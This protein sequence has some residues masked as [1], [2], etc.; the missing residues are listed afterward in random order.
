MKSGDGINAPNSG[1]SFHDQRV[2][3]VFDRHVALSVPEY[4]HV[5]RLIG[6]LSKFFLHDD[7]EVIDYGCATGRTIEEIARE[8]VGRRVG[9]IGVD[10]S[11]P[12]CDKARER[13]SSIGSTYEVVNASVVRVEPTPRTSLMV[14]VYVL[15]FMTIADR[16]DAL[17]MMAQARKGT[18]LILVEKTTPDEP[19]FAVPFSDI[20]HDE[21]L[22]SYSPEEVIG[23]ARSLRGVL[24]PMTANDTETMLRET[25]WKPQRFWQHLSFVGWVCT[26]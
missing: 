26:R 11:V 2:A 9:Y 12:M 23:K 21:K 20:H 6:K 18:G 10:E 22:A 4:D 8:N 3:D 5:Q 25:G 13:L 15:Q 7:A 14:A 16:A 17:Q 19:S 1:F 24:R